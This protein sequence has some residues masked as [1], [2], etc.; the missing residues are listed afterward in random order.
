MS[1]VPEGM[2]RCEWFR[3]LCQKC[4]EV[5]ITAN[6]SGPGRRC[7]CGEAWRVAPERVATGW[8]ARTLPVVVKL[9]FRTYF[10]ESWKPASVAGLERGGAPR[11]RATRRAVVAVDPWKHNPTL[12]IVRDLLLSRRGEWVSAEEVGRVANSKTT[13]SFLVR[14]R[15]LG[16]AVEVRKDRHWVDGKRIAHSFYRLAAPSAPSEAH[17]S[18]AALP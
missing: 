3:A 18:P 10:A 7:S 12:G 9:G 4:G 13:G 6:G 14:L 8:S 16:F 11:K 5:R 1:Q 17:P 2:Q 15:E